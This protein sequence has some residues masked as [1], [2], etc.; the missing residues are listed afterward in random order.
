MVSDS[1]STWLKRYEDLVVIHV[2]GRTHEKQI[3]DDYAKALPPSNV[4]R[5]LVK[6]YVEDLYRYSGAADLVIARA[7]A[8]NIAEF[9]VQA[10]ACIIVP[11]P[12]LTGGHQLK[13]AEILEKSGAVKVV[14]EPKT[15]AGELIAA[16]IELL[17]NAT[18]RERLEQNIYSF[19]KPDS[20]RQLSELIRRNAQK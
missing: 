12:L 17:D 2:A 9:A 18:E 20:A 16:T 15:G 13:N 7:G 4:A 10:K 8:T 3:A 5:V 11:N 19:A 14:K 6:G 1:V